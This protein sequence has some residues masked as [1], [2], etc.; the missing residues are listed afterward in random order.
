MGY[1]WGCERL[2]GSQILSLQ[3]KFRF[4]SVKT[5]NNSLVGMLNSEISIVLL[6]AL[7]TFSLTLLT[8]IFMF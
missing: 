5:K 8:Q 3:F 2:N 1:G 7:V 4:E 6:E